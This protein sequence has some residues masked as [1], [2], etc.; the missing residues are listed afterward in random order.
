MNVFTSFSFVQHLVQLISEVPTSGVG[1]LAL[2]FC[3]HA[4]FDFSLANLP[5]SQIGISALACAC[6]I[7]DLDHQPLLVELAARNIIIVVSLIISIK[8]GKFITT[9]F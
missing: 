7:L 6:Q 8:R 9:H 4:I 3:R 1:N 5:P 2:E